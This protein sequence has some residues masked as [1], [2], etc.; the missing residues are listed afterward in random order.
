MGEDAKL[1]TNETVRAAL[2][3]VI[4]PE[5]GFNIVDLGLIYAIAIEGRTLEVTMT[6]TTPGCP[7]QDYIVSG[8]ERRLGREDGVTRHLRRRGLGP[9]VVAQQDVARREG[10]F[11]HSRGRRVTTT[12]VPDTEACGHQ[13]PVRGGADGPGPGRRGR[14]GM[15][16]GRSRLVR[17][18]PR[19]T[20]GGR[21]AE[22]RA[23]RPY[24][25]S[26]SPL[27]TKESTHV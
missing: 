7:A 16:P 20:S 6:M 15:P 21:A 2:L 10:A 26:S 11:P 23:A 25:A 5:L 12:T 24:P 4:D 13:S 27:K 14:T 9:A 8:V 3:D 17:A 19:P 1:P 22:C 18:A